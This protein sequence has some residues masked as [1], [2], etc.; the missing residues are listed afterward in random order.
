MVTDQQTMNI[1]ALGPRLG[2][3]ILFFPNKEISGRVNVTILPE[4]AL[5]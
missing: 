3:S 2:G 5:A 4:E 1:L